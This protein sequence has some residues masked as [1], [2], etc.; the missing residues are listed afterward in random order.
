MECLPLETVFWFCAGSFADSAWGRR[1]W[2][3]LCGEGLGGGYCTP[4]NRTLRE[5]SELIFGGGL[6]GALARPSLLRCGRVIH[7]RFL[8]RAD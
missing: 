7:R 2:W 5:R 3:S 6:G 4:P 8:A 1:G